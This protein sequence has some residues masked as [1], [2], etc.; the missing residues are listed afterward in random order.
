MNRVIFL[1]KA[2]R[3]YEIGEKSEKTGKIK[4]A[5]GVWKLPGQIKKGKLVKFPSKKKKEYTASEF[6]Y[7]KNKFIDHIERY[8]QT[9]EKWIKKLKE[10]SQ[11]SIEQ[12]S[13]II[14]SIKDQPFGE[15][16]KKKI[17]KYQLESRVNRPDKSSVIKKLKRKR[18]SSQSE[19]IEKNDDGTVKNPKT[20]HQYMKGRMGPYMKK[21]GG[22][23]GA[24]KQMGVEWK[25]LKEKNLKD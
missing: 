24:V 8:P 22:H 25:A 13:E 19:E 14:N 7:F 20:W 1:L 3:S 15:K 16:P 11:L 2:R 21:H 10:H 9:K 18:K 4:V 12:R 17:K 6:N 23:A 5:P